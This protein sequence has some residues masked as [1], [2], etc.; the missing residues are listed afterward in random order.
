MLQEVTDQIQ[1]VLSLRKRRIID[2]SFSEFPPLLGVHRLKHVNFLNK[3]HDERL[4]NTLNHGLALLVVLTVL[5]YERNSFENA[6]ILSLGVPIG[7]RLLRY[8]L[9]Y[10]LCG[11]SLDHSCVIPAYLLECAGC[12]HQ[13][14]FVVHG[15]YDVLDKGSNIV[16]YHF[17]HAFH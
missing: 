16:L 7:S 6:F 3:R 13:E 10:Y 4:D 14:V 2:F 8:H 17:T 5:N 1:V 12:G 11:M 15:G 9:I